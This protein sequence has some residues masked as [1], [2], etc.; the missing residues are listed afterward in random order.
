MANDRWDP[1]RGVWTL[2]DT[3][4]RLVH[5][6]VVRPTSSLL[7]GGRGY[8]PIDVIER[9]DAYILR[10]T[11]PGVNPGDLQ[12]TLIG[13]TVTIRGL[14]RG[15]EERQ[16]GQSWIVRERRGASFYRSVT[17]PTP[18]DADQAEARYEHG[19]LTLT[20]PKAEAQPRQIRIGGSTQPT[21]D[22]AV[23]ASRSSAQSPDPR[24][25]DP[26]DTVDE[27]SQG[28]YGFRVGD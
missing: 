24:P 1:F 17:L 5:E 10:A 25:E 16:E 28:S 11:M 13:T 23:P 7:S 19:V 4:D 22:T 27:A 20:L 26:Y 21:S 9:A 8:L 15:E 6:N 14:S 12:V 2:R 3:L 18:A